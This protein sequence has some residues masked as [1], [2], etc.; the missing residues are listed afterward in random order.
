[1]NTSLSLQSLEFKEKFN[2]HYVWLSLYLFGMIESFPWNQVTHVKC[3]RRC[4]WIRWRQLSI[5]ETKDIRHISMTTHESRLN[6]KIKTQLLASWKRKHRSL[7]QFHV[8]ALAVIKCRTMST[9]LCMGEIKAAVM[10]WTTALRPEISQYN[11]RKTWATLINCYPFVP[12]VVAFVVKLITCGLP[13][14]GWTY[15]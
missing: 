11:D 12:F 14:W 5:M 1:M 2:F 9:N 7:L 13:V 10:N 3:E 6:R 15:L 8:S 4:G